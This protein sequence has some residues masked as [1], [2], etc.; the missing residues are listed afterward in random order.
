MS[1]VYAVL[2]K[3]NAMH[4]FAVLVAPLFEQNLQLHPAPIYYNIT[5]HHVTRY[6]VK[7]YQVN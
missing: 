3:L 5:E 6:D 7:E 1:T 4:N 2:P